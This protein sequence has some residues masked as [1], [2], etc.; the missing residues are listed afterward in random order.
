MQALR[1]V[2]PEAPATWERASRADAA[3]V[4]L[5]DGHA[6][7]RDV[8]TEGSMEVGSRRLRLKLRADWLR[9]SR[10]G[11]FQADRTVV[12]T[13]DYESPHYEIRI[14]DLRMDR[15]PDPE[16]Q[17]R[18]RRQQRNGT[19]DPERPIDTTNGWNVSSTKTGIAFGEEMSLPLPPIEFPL[20]D[21]FRVPRREI[22]IFGIQPLS[23]GTDARFGAFISARF[24]R[25]LGAASKKIARGID[26][27]MGRPPAV[28]TGSWGLEARY[29][30]SRGL[31]LNV[32]QVLESEG[33]YRIQNN[34]GFI[35]DGGQDRGLVRV[36]KSDRENL[37]LW[38]RMRSRFLLDPEEWVDLVVTKQTDPG[39]QSEFYQDKFLRFEE[40][41]SFVHWRKAKELDFWRATV[42]LELDGHRTEVQEQPSFGYYRGR[43]QV[44]SLWGR[45]VN[46]TSNSELARFD[47]VE[48][49]P[50]YEAPFADGFGDREAVRFDTSH[51]IDRPTPLGKMGLI[52]T[53]YI[54]A[55]GT[56]WDRGANGG[57]MPRRAALIAGAVLGTSFWRNFQNGARHQLVP[58][59]GLRGDLVHEQEGGTPAQF[60]DVESPIDGRFVDLRLLSRLVLPRSQ[61]GHRRF[62]DLELTETH[63]AAVAPGQPDG[64]LPIRVNAA[65]LDSVFGIPI[66]ATHDGRYDVQNGQTVY[67][68]TFFGF[69]PLPQLEIETGYHSGRMDDGTLSYSAFSTAARYTLSEKW[70]V[71]GRQ[72]ISS[73]NNRT[74]SSGLLVRRFGHDFVFDVGLTFR[75]GEGG[76]TLKFNL[77]PLLVW[78]K[79]PIGLL[80][81]W[82]SVDE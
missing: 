78:R 61:S 36:P 47:R 10:N 72:T 73:S 67:S 2:A 43:G 50:N 12:T 55:R 31:A 23:F 76:S 68:R 11:S 77:T 20:T 82:I 75:A 33:R 41:E 65:Y 69:D 30:G 18:A 1:S 29:L 64:W 48:G 39:V 4:D 79:P 46:Y 51:R 15:R 9:H 40:R 37:R 5:I 8:V 58:T 49:D 56:V 59:V 35:T 34:V 44:G 27:A 16:A 62:L 63:A 14:G 17:E 71:E 74:L 28:P 32:D 54:E 57:S 70:Q 26:W 66:G 21:R 80:D 45:P 3:Y 6:W 22:K 42:E 24:V 52:A 38:Y 53:P 25:P 19:A 7:I 60:D 81:R 13:C